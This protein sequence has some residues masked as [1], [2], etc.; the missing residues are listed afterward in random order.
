MDLL[1]SILNKMTKPP[2]VGEQQKKAIQKQRE[3]ILKRQEQERVQLKNFQKKIEANIDSFAKDNTLEKLTL[4]PMNKMQRSIVHEIAETAGLS[5]FSFG[6]EDVDRHVVV[7]KKEFTPGPDELNAYRKG[8][9]WNPDSVK[10]NPE[11]EDEEDEQ[12]ASKSDSTVSSAQ[13]VN[14]YDRLIGKEAVKDAVKVTQVNR[15]YGFV[16]S[17]NKKD[18]R[19]IEQTLADIRAKKRQK[20]E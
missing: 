19:S 2:T 18:Q 8:I 13:Y 15:K 5:A 1:G 6:E 14:K 7:Y 17:E 3:D 16:S 10:Q 11:P 9:P 12:P 4:Q 20:T